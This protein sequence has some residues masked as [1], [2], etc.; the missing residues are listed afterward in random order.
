[1]GIYIFFQNFSK[2][3]IFPSSSW[4]DVNVGIF[5][6]SSQKF[7]WWPWFFQTGFHEIPKLLF[8][9]STKL[10]SIHIW[11]FHFDFSWIQLASSE[12]CQV[13]KHFQISSF[14]REITSMAW[15]TWNHI[16]IFPWDFSWNQSW[17]RWKPSK[18]TLSQLWIWLNFK[19]SC[20]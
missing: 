15:G 4:N 3:P 13:S 12:L 19:L 10:I 8:G 5:M 9:P 1:M 18:Q 6:F 16:S 20:F 14:F 17:V 11:K 7:P 2:F